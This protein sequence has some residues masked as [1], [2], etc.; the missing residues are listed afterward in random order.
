MSVLITA[1]FILATVNLFGNLINSIQTEG[2]SVN[3]S[4]KVYYNIPE[5]D[6]EVYGK[7]SSK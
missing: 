4:G 5:K 6:E 7:P 3:G 2:Q 1:V